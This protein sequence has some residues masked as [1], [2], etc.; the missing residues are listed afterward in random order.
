M[1]KVVWIVCIP[2]LQL[3]ASAQVDT[4]V[5]AFEDLPIHIQLDVAVILIGTEALAFT[6][7]LQDAVNDLPVL[8]HVVVSRLLCRGEFINRHRS[9]RLWIP[10]K[11]LPTGQI[12]AV[13][14]G[15]E[16]LWRLAMCHFIRHKHG[17]E[18]KNND[19][20]SR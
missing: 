17:R 10:H 8:A 18:R 19:P 3:R 9:P 12:L 20:N 11:S 15:C 14:Q 16:S 13:E 5:T 1:A 7:E 2:N 4:A 6:I